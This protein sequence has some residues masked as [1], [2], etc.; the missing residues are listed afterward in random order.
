MLGKYVSGVIS[1]GN[2]CQHKVPSAYSV[3]Y[4]KIGHMEVPNLSKTPS[5]TYTNSGCGVRQ[6]L[7]IE[8]N[9]KISGNGLQ[10]EGK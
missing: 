10:S 5:P 1:P 9:A 7:D 8:N 6:D 3:L 2:L 4:P